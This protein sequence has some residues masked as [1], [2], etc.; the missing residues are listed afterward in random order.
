MEV[1]ETGLNAVQ[2]RTYLVGASQLTVIRGDIVQSTCEVLVSSD[3]ANLSMGGGVS[4]AI[5][6][7]GGSQFLQYEA[8]KKPQSRLGD[9]VVTSA[10]ALPAIGTGVARLDY[11]EVVAERAEVI[12]GFLLGTTDPYRIE[13]YVYDRFG[14]RRDA[15]TSA[16]EALH[17]PVE[18]MEGFHPQRPTTV[19]QTDLDA[20]C[21]TLT[22]LGRRRPHAGLS[23][24]AKPSGPL[25]VS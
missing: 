13:L 7:A 4:H 11:T 10:G 21:H 18:R 15:V 8:W 17:R 24:D 19:T 20:T 16:L 23:P 25:G 3:D 9:I 6:T 2:S 1:H 14:Q 22:A 5:M 12:V